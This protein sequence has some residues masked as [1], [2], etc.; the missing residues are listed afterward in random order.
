MKLYAMYLASASV[1]DLRANLSSHLGAVKAGGEVLITERGQPIARI[2]PVE[3]ELAESVR[4]AD[5]VRSGLVR[6]PTTS[7]TEEFLQRP[8][9][10]D[11]EGEGV[12]AI[13]EERAE[14]P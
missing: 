7:F 1:A 2:V 6:E 14:G 4:I 3:G 8:R 9:P 5:L 11:P 10:C 13:L 12:R